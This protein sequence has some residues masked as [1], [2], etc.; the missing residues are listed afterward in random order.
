MNLWPSPAIASG[1][2]GLQVL[3]PGPL[4]GFKFCFVRIQGLNRF[5]AAAQLRRSR[6]G[7][8]NKEEEERLRPD[9]EMGKILKT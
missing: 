9:W 7:M 3:P 5:I 4:W 2:L 8:G 1:V 6:L